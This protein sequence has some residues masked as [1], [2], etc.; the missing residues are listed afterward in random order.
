VAALA[1][2]GCAIPRFDLPGVGAS[3]EGTE[4]LV[5]NRVWLQRD[6]DDGVAAYGMFLSNG[7]MVT[8]RCG[9]P[10][11]FAAWRWVDESVMVWED[12]DSTRRAEVAAVGPRELALVLDMDGAN[13]ALS[14]E[15]VRPPFTCE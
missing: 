8:G 6:P 9:G 1:L 15:A 12:G 7:T 4:E 5:E 11:S 13:T 3:N 14:F 2:S 10:A